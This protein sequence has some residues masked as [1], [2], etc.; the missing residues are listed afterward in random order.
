MKMKMIH[1]CDRVSRRGVA[2]AFFLLVLSGAVAGTRAG[3]PASP[4]ADG[5][6]PR[7]GQASPLATEAPVY[8]IGDAKGCGPEG[9][10]G[11]ERSGRKRGGD[12]GARSPYDFSWTYG[13]YYGDTRAPRGQEWKETQ[14]FMR[15]YTP[16]RQNALD[17]MAEGD[18]KESIKRFVFARFRGLQS[19]QRQDPAGY[20]QRLAQL[21]IEDDIFGLLAD[22]GGAAEADQQQLVDDLRTQVRRLVE[23]DLQERQRRVDALKIELEEQIESLEKDRGQFG[24]LV[25]RR[26]SRFTE[27]ARQRAAWRKDAQSEMP[28]ATA[29]E[30]SKKR[31]AD[32]HDGR[33]GDAK[34]RRKKRD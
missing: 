25:E 30:E 24:M 20:Q 10:G 22:W 6:R 32:R 4:D 18:K 2:G 17:E 19:I 8:L 9:D 27:W 16:R 11:E 15:R 29:D 31:D 28:T 13:R 34:R 3:P 21:Q 5:G 14:D 1:F 7:C 26:V 12:R 23:L 33:E